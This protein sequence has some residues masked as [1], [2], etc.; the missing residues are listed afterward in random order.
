MGDRHTIKHTANRF[1]Q[2]I[3]F[4]SVDRPT[5]KN[6]DVR[7]LSYHFAPRQFTGFA[8]HANNQIF[9]PAPSIPFVTKYMVNVYF[10]WGVTTDRNAGSNT[11]PTRR[12]HGVPPGTFLCDITQRL[13]TAILDPGHKLAIKSEIKATLGH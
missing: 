11:A 4:V 5:V 7:S 3:A 8:L 6:C 10:F 2:R 9:L 1:P 12:F 13:G